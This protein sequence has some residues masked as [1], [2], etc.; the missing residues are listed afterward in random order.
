M[1]EKD[2]ERRNKE[3]AEE[4][5]ADFKA[6][7]EERRSYE[8]S[9]LLNINFLIGN[10]Y[11][12]ISSRGAVDEKGMLFPWESRE[13]FN[14]I[15]PIIESRL[16]KL[17]RVK[18]TMAVRPSG[19]EQ[20][21]VE[22]AKLSKSIL[23]SVSVEKGLSDLITEAT[24]WSEVAGTSFYKVYFDETS[25]EKIDAN[26][27]LIENL[28]KNEEFSKKY[29]DFLEK[30]LNANDGTVPLG[31]VKIKVVSPF[32]IFP[33]SPAYNS[34]D[35]C[36]SIIHAYPISVLEAEKLYGRPFVGEDI[37]MLGMDT[38][39]MP[40]FSG[41]ASSVLKTASKVKH[42]QVMCYEKYVK[43]NLNHKNGQ[44][45]I[46]VGDEL[47]YEG[48]LPLARYP[49]VRQVSQEVLGSF[50]GS[51]IIERCIPIQRAYNALKNR[52]YEFFARLSAGVLAVEDGSVD[53]DSLEEEG[54]APGKILVYRSGASAPRFMD[55]GDVPSEFNQ[56]EDRL[57][58]E[59]I[60]LTGVS[61]LM[62]NSTLPTQVTSGT[63]INLLIE[64]DDT[65]LQVTAENIRK[66]VLELGKRI[67]MLYKKYATYPKLSKVVDENGDIQVFYWTSSDISSCDVV[68]ETTNE[69]SETPTVRK[70]MILELLK[71]GLLYD[72]NGKISKRNKSK[73]FEALGF[74]NW[75][76]SQDI[77]TLHVK[78]A[79]KENLGLLPLV[80][81]EIDDHDI[82]IEE[83]KKYLLSDEASKMSDEEKDRYI[84]HIRE[85]NLFRSL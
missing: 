64:Q 75:E 77:I 28:K 42:N 68:L 39:S 57:L 2:N 85:H 13:V 20:S 61:E 9:W 41:G 15:A 56:E 70:N 14:H 49:F 6:R 72:E 11:S 55:A 66:A 34:I 10:Q 71:N 43:P 82:H 50:W 12:Y 37:S 24:V 63:A 52:K 32:E 27:K 16:A 1:K 18:P 59:F 58:N 79:S 17:A 36:E 60:T 19:S 45:L 33:D 53:I 22:V 84:Q 69:L 8:L 23:D 54:L 21:D 38:S 26:D 62:R 65:R 30:T 5:I 67:L 51:S 47:V 78:K 74:G 83:H 35:E 40:F 80:V 46:V 81:S 4:V 31:D 76:S 25:G 29:A 73:I 44:L 3:I 48:E 7:Q